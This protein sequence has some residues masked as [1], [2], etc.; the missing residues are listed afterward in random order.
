MRSI[1]RARW[2][3]P[4]S[5][6][7]L[8]F[9]AAC[10]VKEELLQPQNPG[11]IDQTAVGSPTAAAALKI[12]AMG[13][14]KWVV[15]DPAPAGFGGSSVWE[16]SGLLAMEAMV[17]GVPLIATDCVGLRE[18]VSRSPARVATS[19]NPESLAKAQTPAE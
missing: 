6:I 10:N 17:C 1:F 4:G 15:S 18:T 5:V 9:T 7:V 16:A 12:G 13:R 11:L 14:L 8:G 19:G 2:A 3:I